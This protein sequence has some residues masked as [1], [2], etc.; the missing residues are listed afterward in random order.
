MP[1]FTVHSRVFIAAP[2]AAVYRVAADPAVVP[3]YAREVRRIE[4]LG[5]DGDRARVRV[6][7]RVGPLTLRPV[8]RYVYRPPRLYAGV[9]EGGGLVRGFFGMTFR[10]E[11]AGTRVAHVEGIRSPLP[12]LA[13]ALG[14]AVLRR[15]AIEQELARLKRL[16]EEG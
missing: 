14:R 16:V 10:P 4:I 9:Q 7:L 11:G 13:R 6:H 1:T 15:R 5:R 8:Y 2:P 3:R 12:L